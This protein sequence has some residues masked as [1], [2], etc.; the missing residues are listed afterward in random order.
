MKDTVA[1]NQTFDIYICTSN[2]LILLIVLIICNIYFKLYDK[3]TR[4]GNSCGNEHGH[5]L[6]VK[7][8]DI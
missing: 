5:F 6:I 4:I 2:K 3:L 8:S 7:W 1:G